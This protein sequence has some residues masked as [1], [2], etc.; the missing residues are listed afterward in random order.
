MGTSVAPVARREG[1]SV[2][3]QWNAAV[4]PTIMVRDSETGEVLSFARG[5]Q[6]RVLTAGNELELVLSDGVKSQR[7]RLAISRS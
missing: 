5:G 4:H 6:A 1:P 2:M 7:V 3:I